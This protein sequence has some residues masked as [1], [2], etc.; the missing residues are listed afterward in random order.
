[1]HPAYSVIFFTCLSGAG[2]GLLAILGAELLTGLLP[3]ETGFALAAMTLCLGL[4]I[5]GLL[6]SSLHLHHPERALLAFSQWRSS[7]LSREGVAAVATF[8]P[9][10]GVGLAWLFPAWF[11]W[12]EIAAAGGAIAGA[13]TTVLCTAMIYASLKPVP[14]WRVSWASMPLAPVVYFAFALAGGMACY[15]T[16]LCL[17]AEARAHMLPPA[18]CLAV[19]LAWSAKFLYWRRIDA[20]DA[21]SLLDAT[22]LQGEWRRIHAFDLPHTEPNYLQKEMGYRI[23]RKHR[24]MLRRLAWTGGGAAPIALLLAGGWLSAP[25]AALFSL[26]ATVLLMA[27]TL[28]ERWLFFAEAQHTSSLYYDDKP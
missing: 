10:A 7:W 15:Q 19:A 3:R 14:E 16:L 18:T 5:G 17:F 26:L 2:Y 20:I 11:D 6:C 25:A 4:I 1:M 24:G 28:L 13:A 23:A 22:G 27:G 21:P 8:L 12:L 9:A